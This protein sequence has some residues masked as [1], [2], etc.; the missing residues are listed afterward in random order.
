[1][2][3][4]FISEHYP[5]T[6]G[7]V[8]TS[9]QRVARELVIQ[10]ADV[11]VFCFDHSMPI[12]SDDYA[13][14]EI[15]QGVIVHR[16]GPF[17]LKH[18][19]LDQIPEKVKASLRR[20]SFEQTLRIIS[21]GEK[22]EI[23]LSFYLL[24]AGFMGLYVARFLNI[25][26]VSGIRGND[27]GRNIFHVERFG[28]IQWIVDGSS[29]LISVNSHLRDRL[30][31]AFPDVNEKTLVIPNSAPK[32][33]PNISCIESRQRVAEVSGWNDQDLRL[34][35]IGTLREKKG[36]A[37]LLKA[38][39]DAREKRSVRLLVIGSELG[40]IERRMCGD[41]WDSLRQDNT[42]YCTGQV[43]RKEVKNWALGCDAVVMPSL[44]DGM[45]NGLLEGMSLGL[46]PI[47]TTIFCDV[48]N[49]SNGFVVP[50]G[51]SECLA[52]TFVCLDS[53]R[54]WLVKKGK[55]AKKDVEKYTAK[56]EATSYLNTFTEILNSG[57]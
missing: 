36:V 42:L 12:E 25:P 8:A 16:I 9:T 48:V 18:K 44:D 34:V 39:R 33:Q 55:Q 47:A 3:I 10:G 7:G 5:P 53:N 20:R 46:C 38:L 32:I 13:L 50:P 17:F 45:A 31:L 54:E 21:K 24:N 14:T 4:C 49:D 43:S 22:P 41:M 30:L 23:V 29:K 11:Q 57:T 28:V 52:S 6:S 2:R 15:D 37:T 51:D 56:E 35:F 40:S 27:I 26:L 19:N 1:M